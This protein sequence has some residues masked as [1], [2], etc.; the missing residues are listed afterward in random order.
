MSN[1]GFLVVSKGEDPI[2]ADIIFVHGL[3]GKR[4]GTWTKTKVKQKDGSKRDIFW[5]G[6]LLARETWM[7]HV[8]VMS[9]SSISL[10]QLF[11]R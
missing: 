11:S 7:K 1:E 8:R 4:E 9:V 2:S 6:A 3:E 5:P 10:L